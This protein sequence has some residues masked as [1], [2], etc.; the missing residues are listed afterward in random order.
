MPLIPIILIALVVLMF[1]H[2]G[3][4]IVVLSGIA[5]WVLVI[6]GIFIMWSRKSEKRE[7][8]E[9]IQEY[10]RILQSGI[11]EIDGMEGVEF[12]EYLQAL[13]LKMNFGVEMTSITGDYGAD[14]ILTSDNEER[15]AVQAKRYSQPVGVNAIQE[16]N[17][18][19]AYYD[20]NEAWVVTNNRFTKSA[21][22]LAE[23]T[24][25]ALIDRKEL[26]NLIME[27]RVTISV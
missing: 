6:I 12:E 19:K 13:F 8:E 2:P 25:V 15:I 4:V 17:A 27:N 20:C 24:N 14:L 18:A 10:E 23:K 9:R 7:R 3:F 22:E 11:E 5:F 21:R 16:V 26:I 1:F